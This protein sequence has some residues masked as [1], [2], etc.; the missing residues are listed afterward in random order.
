MAGLSAFPWPTLVGG[1][2]PLVVGMLIGSLDREM[3]EFLGRAI[4][5]LIPFFAFALG[6]TLDL[7]RVWQAG[8]LGVGLGLAVVI[9]TVMVMTCVIVRLCGGQLGFRGDFGICSG[10]ESFG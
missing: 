7:A 4:P 6:G 2:L 9:V 5:V 3:R 10:F 1:I 8:L